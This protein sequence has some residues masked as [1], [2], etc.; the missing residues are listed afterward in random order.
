MFREYMQDRY[1]HFTMD[2]LYSQCGIV[3]MHNIIPHLGGRPHSE[4]LKRRVN[5]IKRAESMAK[6]ER[7]TVMY[8]TVTYSFLRDAFVNQGWHVRNTFINKRTDNTV[9]EL[10]KEI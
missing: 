7:Y 8:A 5:M 1:D 9:W 4:L 10:R 6:R 2:K 3:V